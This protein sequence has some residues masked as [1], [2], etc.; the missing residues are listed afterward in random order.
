[1]LEPCREEL[2]QMVHTIW[3][4]SSSDE[5]STAES[6]CWAG[7]VMMTAMASCEYI[8]EA[9]RYFLTFGPDSELSPTAKAFV[10]C[11]IEC[12]R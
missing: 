6:R 10:D 11:T 4:P 5:C 3:L 1:M 12:A 9:E 7:C 2:D 8:V